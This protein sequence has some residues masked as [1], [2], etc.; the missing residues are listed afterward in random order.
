M[1]SNEASAG[2]GDKHTAEAGSP[3]EM[4]RNT[5]SIAVG[6]LL[7]F[8][9]SNLAVSLIFDHFFRPFYAIAA[10]IGA[11]IIL[12]ARGGRLKAAIRT[13]EAAFALLIL[14]SAFISENRS[15]GVLLSF[16]PAFSLLCLYFDGSRTLAPITG[17]AAVTCA[18]WY[19][20]VGRVSFGPGPA[21]TYFVL[22]F[23]VQL[24]IF[25]VGSD[26][27]YALLDS[28]TLLLELNHRVRNL[29]QIVSS[30]AANTE[31][32]GR[33][34]E[35]SVPGSHEPAEGCSLAIQVEALQA[36]EDALTLSSDFRQADM[37]VPLEAIAR[38]AG[39]K[40]GIRIQVRGSALLSFDKAVTL[41]ILLAGIV[42]AEARRG[43]GRALALGLSVEGERGSLDLEA[44]DGRGLER[45][46][47]GGAEDPAS[48]LLDQLDAHV[49]AEETR[50]RID[51]DAAAG[52]SMLNRLAEGGPRFEDRFRDDSWSPLLGT[53][54][55][56]K[57]RAHRK[58]ARTLLFYVT[59]E[60]G[61]LG[62][63]AAYSW[64]SSGAL[65]YSALLMMAVCVATFLL[66]RTGKLRGAA[67]LF[68][69]AGGLISLFAVLC[70]PDAGRG[71][72][73]VTVQMFFLFAL[74]FLGK[75][76]G[77][78]LG[79]WGVVVYAAWFFWRPP[80]TIPMTAFQSYCIA[81]SFFYVAAFII[82]QEFNKGIAKNE[83]IALHFKGSLGR[84]IGL[85][86]AFSGETES[87]YRE[88][89]IG[90]IA[91]IAAAHTIVTGDDAGGDLEAG[92]AF[93]AYVAALPDG[94][95][96]NGLRIRIAT[97]VRLPSETVYY[98]LLL[99]GEIWTC[100]IGDA[101]AGGQ[102]VALERRAKSVFLTV[103]GLYLNP[104]NPA[105]SS[106][107]SYLKR[108]EDRL[109]AKRMDRGEDEYRL[110]LDV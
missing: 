39:E 14:A 59:V 21:L 16:L 110:R 85:L 90:H 83:D 8:S 15:Y 55:R 75:P 60:F 9:V 32:D 13:M 31:S 7:I 4:R 6:L 41:T 62:I 34:D 70:G 91:A 17:Y 46:A 43:S 5:L 63:L 28:R 58:K 87:A 81:L 37:R 74:H 47:W 49:V 33:A 56:G 54:N 44:L 29:L 101:G 68:V 80:K 48:L 45:G 51:F 86:A 94:D 50:C 103:R 38:A 78:L 30:L 95:K 66:A 98:L 72:Q 57:S 40:Q 27:H 12:L 23:Y 3:D 104:E 109:G 19:L 2:K 64:W 77:L 52:P 93:R 11:A 106:R 42:S 69:G 10:V 67:A 82:I 89:I 53:R 96:V 22:L 100:W 107:A 20:A 24:L 99:M 25:L 1:S 71:L 92:P 26:L 76:A 97:K 18:A 108:I 65:R 84:S 36:I 61:L 105:Y 88:R 35:N 102:E 73:L 79:V